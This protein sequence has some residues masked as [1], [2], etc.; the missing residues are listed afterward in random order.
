MTD[1]RLKEIKQQAKIYGDDSSAVIAALIQADAM[2]HLAK[3]IGFGCN[4]IACKLE[5][6]GNI[7]Q[8]GKK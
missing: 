8:H 3:K 2:E 7:M 6:I 4:E 1:E 5:D